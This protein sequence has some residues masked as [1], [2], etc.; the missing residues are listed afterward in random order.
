M[1]DRKESKKSKKSHSDHKS[2][3]KHKKH[4][5]RHDKNDSPSSEPEIDYND[6]SLWSV[7]KTIEGV[8]P[9]SNVAPSAAT[10]VAPTAVDAAPVPVQDDVDNGPVRD[11]WMT[12]AGM[13]FTSF[14]TVKQKAPKE[15]KPNPDVLQV[16]SRE[17]NPHF[18]AGL[19]IDQYPEQPK[20]TYKIGD[21]GSKWRMTKLKRTMEQAEDEGRSLQ[22]V[23]LEKYG[24][25]EKF[26]E[27]MHERRELDRRQSGR[28]RGDDQRDRRGRHDNRPQ[29]MFSDSAS[30][31]RGSFKRPQEKSNQS[32]D[33]DEFGRER[34]AKRSLSPSPDEKEV[35]AKLAKAIS[36]TTAPV[37]ARPVIISQHSNP[38]LFSEK[39]PLTTDELNKL[40]AKVMKAKLMGAHNVAELEKEYEEEKKRADEHGTKR[41]P[42]VSIVP[43]I[44]SQGKLHEFAISSS[45]KVPV[46]DGPRKRKEKFEGTHDSQTGERLKYGSNDDKLSLDDLVRQEKA[47]SRSATDMDMDLAN[48]IAGDVTFED[49]LEYM[50]EQAEKMATKKEKTE[51][52]KIRH[53]INDHKRSQQ[54]LDSCR[55]CYQD[56]KPPQCAMISLGTKTYLSLPNVTDLTPGHCFIVPLQHSVSSLECDDDVWDEIRNFQKCLIRMFHEQGKGVVFMEL[57]KN[58]KYQRH[59][60]IECI[61][62][63]YGVVEDAPMYF[64]EAIMSAGDEWSQHK[65]VI[66][67]GKKGFR[68]S[69]VKEMPYF[70]VWFNPNEG[71]GH[72][73]ED[74]KEFPGWFG[75]EIV[76][77]MMDLPP[78][79]WRKPRFQNAKDNQERQRAFLK[80]WQKYDWTAALEGGHFEQ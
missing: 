40:N 56:G 45:S 80:N 65:K 61:P 70:H 53:A 5:S 38:N 54:A 26:E 14:G 12:D 25:M 57:V 41:D 74:E 52:A 58:M 48:R 67:T 36:S 3:K 66:D 1:G 72:V 76:A 21:A 30:S 79:L 35:K 73:I 42:S 10:A 60:V 37:P 28:G 34:R 19:S 43:T 62:I 77:G 55:W 50:D 7:E 15:E 33:V 51:E 13:D 46:S 71:Y 20:S 44:D 8:A 22:E 27:A 4:R 2:H 11:T 49:D 18:K 64:Q 6:P 63:P 32:S 23:A 31:S 59:T 17:I 29:M 75:K 16:S 68:R 39:P 69:M 78:Y 9:V 24:S 47:G